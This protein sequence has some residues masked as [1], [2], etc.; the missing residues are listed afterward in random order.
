VLLKNNPIEPL[1]QQDIILNKLYEKTH[2]PTDSNYGTKLA[3]FSAVV[4]ESEPDLKNI[5]R[6]WPIRAGQ[7]V[8]Y[9]W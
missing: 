3:L 9:L 1:W 2:Y 4:R 5:R 7:S 6:N 8:A